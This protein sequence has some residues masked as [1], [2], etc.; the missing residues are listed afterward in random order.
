MVMFYFVGM[1]IRGFDL[2]EFW[3]VGLLLRFWI[4]YYIIILVVVC[5]FWWANGGF[6]YEF[7]SIF[8][9][10]FECDV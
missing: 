9:V 3:K 7:Y 10:R 5:F 6:W 2:E 8:F 1:I 4:L